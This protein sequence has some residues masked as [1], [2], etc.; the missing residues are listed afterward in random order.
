MLNRR[1]LRIKLFQSLYAY[2]QNDTTQLPVALKN[3]MISLEKMHELLVLNVSLMIRIAHVLDERFESQKQKFIQA[4]ES[5]NALRRLSSNEGIENLMSNTAF[6]KFIAD[7]SIQWGGEDELLKKMAKSIEESKEYK[8][9]QM[10]GDTAN[11]IQYLKTIYKKH[12]YTH[13]SFLSYL[14]ELNI[15]WVHDQYY[16]GVILMSLMKKDSA[17]NNAQIPFP[18][19]FKN[20]DFEE[21]ESDLEFANT[22]F[23]K[24]ITEH[25]EYDNIIHQYLENWEPDRIALTDTI[26]MRMACAEILHFNQIPVRVSLNEYIELS[27]SYSTPKSKIFVNGILDKVIAHYAR[28]GKFEKIGRGLQEN[29]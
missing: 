19:V 13:S 29:N 18:E 3:L 4:D 9:F 2:F 12:I 25:K 22:L 14:E 11:D 27:K 21:A 28:E 7:Y 10:S 5:V 23:M 16:I 6:S 1:L 20:N 8:E 24:T 26:I 15:H 17:F